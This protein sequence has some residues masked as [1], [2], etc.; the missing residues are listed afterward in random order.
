MKN[1]HRFIQIV[2]LLIFVG[3]APVTGVIK[4]K[5]TDNVVKHDNKV[6]DEIK[7]AILDFQDNRHDADGK[8]KMIGTVYGGYKNPLIRIYSEKT[9][10]L[11]I[12]DAVE[13]LLTANGFQV[14][15]YP[16]LTDYSSLAGE[17]YIVKGKINKFWT[18]SFYGTG[19]VVDIDIE[20]FDRQYKKIWSGKFEDY[21]RGG[22]GGGVAA[23]TN[24]MILML[25]EV[26]S[27]AIQKAWLEQ[28]MQNALE[29]LKK[30]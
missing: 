28:G 26:F 9:I 20:I 16:G 1:Y 19:A 13:N 22:I 2:L 6:S 15:K 27:G 29:S 24:K 10:C 23:D 7:I 17:K 8:E 21:K 5:P 4:Y 12:M 11:D 30:E 18:E 3:C 25:N 14:N